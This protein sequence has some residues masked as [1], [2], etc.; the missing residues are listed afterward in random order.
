[1]K[2]V[3]IKCCQ[4]DLKNKCGN[5]FYIHQ[6]DLSLLIFMLTEERKNIFF[7]S[8]KKKIKIFLPFST[9]LEVAF[10]NFSGKVP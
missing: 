9:I 8:L 5:I 10:N 1:M 6:D 2:T 3:A 4:G 7:N